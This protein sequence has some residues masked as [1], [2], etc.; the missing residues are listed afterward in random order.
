MDPLTHTLTGL[1]ISRAGFHR[2]LPKATPLLILAANAPDVDIVTRL[3][4]TDLYLL[5][6]RGPT[7]SLLLSPLVALSV[8]L[9]IR[10]VARKKPSYRRALLPAWIGVLSH[11]LL[12]W[13][14]IYG[15]RLLWPITEQ[16]FQLDINFIIDLWIWA[17]LLVAVIVPGLSQLLGKEIG[18]GQP[19]YQFWAILALC[20]FVGYDVFKFVLHQR[21]VDSLEAFLY[22]RQPPLRVAA[23]PHPLDPWR[24]LGLVETQD[25]YHLRPLN[26]RKLSPPARLFSFAK[27]PEAELA[28][29]RWK[30]LR[31]VQAFL[32]FSQ[33]PLYRQL[34]A[35]NDGVQLELRGWDLRFGLPTEDRF[36]LHIR[37]GP[38]EEVIE[39]FFRFGTFRRQRLH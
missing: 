4:G 39:C 3:G 17:I 30:H 6:H 35:T 33:F 19:N 27:Q 21:A 26:L 9:L 12:D 25:A 14:N 24:W 22:Q 37:L 36:S 23:L 29:Q 32:S 10:A 28:V 18:A 2:N 5:W 31:P 16:W 7:H 1:A 11:V 38:N 20:A 15:I 13:T 8:V 34:P